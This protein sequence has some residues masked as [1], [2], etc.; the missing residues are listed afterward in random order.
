MR[1]YFNSHWSTNRNAFGLIPRFDVRRPYP[2]LSTNFTGETRI[3]HTRLS[4][5]L[6]WLSFCLQ[7]V[8]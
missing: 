3:R 4:M 7:V 2:Y 5:C 8:W 6:Y 1:V